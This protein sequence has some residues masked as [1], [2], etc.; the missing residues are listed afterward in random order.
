[1]GLVLNNLQRLI[2]HKKRGCPCGVMVKALDCGIIVFLFN[3]K[4]IYMHTVM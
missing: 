4:N 1:M 2:C 3:N